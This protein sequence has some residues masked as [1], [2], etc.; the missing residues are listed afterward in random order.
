ML[1]VFLLLTL[2]SGCAVIGGI[3]KAGVWF[4]VTLVVLVIALIFYLISRINRKG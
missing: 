1:P 3:F 4:G 2:L